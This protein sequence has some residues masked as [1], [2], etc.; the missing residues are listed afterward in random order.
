MISYLIKLFL[1]H[2][3]VNPMGFNLRVTWMLFQKRKSMHKLI[4]QPQ[5]LN[6]QKMIYFELRS[7]C[8]MISYDLYDSTYE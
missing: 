4:I 1:S 3:E 8:K 5:I 6:Y 7:A 2:F